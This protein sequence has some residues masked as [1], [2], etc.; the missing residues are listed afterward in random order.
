MVESRRTQAIWLL[1]EGKGRAQVRAITTYSDDALRELVLA[2]NARGLAALR[3][4]RHANPGANTVLSDGELLVFARTLRDAAQRDEPMSA[5]EAL[6]FVQRAFGKTVHLARIYEIFSA[7]GLT[8]QT[9]RPRHALSSVVEQ[10]AFKKSSPNGSRQ[11]Q[12]VV[13]QLNFGH[14]TSTASD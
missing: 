14:R 6:A 2:Y 3:D 8:K 12:Q 11:L 5:R 1:L 13:A 9:T 4:G 10:Q 7:V